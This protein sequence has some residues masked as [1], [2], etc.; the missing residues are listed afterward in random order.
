MYWSCAYRP[1]PATLLKRHLRTAPS[2]LP[3]YPFAFA[4]TLIRRAQIKKIKVER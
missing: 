3:L 2:L 1:V 4:V